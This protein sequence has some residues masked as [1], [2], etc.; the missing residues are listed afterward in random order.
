MVKAS[1]DDSV[2]VE[3][4][5]QKSEKIKRV[6]ISGDMAGFIEELLAKAIKKLENF[7]KEREGLLLVVQCYKRY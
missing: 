5:H 4:T 1:K 7:L 2:D 6:R 3:E